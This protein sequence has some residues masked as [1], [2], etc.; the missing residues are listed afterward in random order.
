VESA[1][2]RKG[3]QKENKPRT[4]RNVS[5]KKILKEFLANSL[6]ILLIPI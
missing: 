3:K 2:N 5:G 4:L 1:R 6:I